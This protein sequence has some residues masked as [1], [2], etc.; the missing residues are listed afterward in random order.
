[1]SNTGHP[2]G[3]EEVRTISGQLEIRFPDG[4]KVVK[5]P[6]GHR[7]TVH[8]DGRQLSELADGTT[9]E[10]Y[11]D[12]SKIQRNATGEVLRVSADGDRRTTYLDGSEVIRR[13]DGVRIVRSPGGAVTETYPDGRHVD[14]DGA[15]N[16]L[17]TF[18]DGRK[19]QTDPAG[20]RAER[21]P[22]GT[23]L[24]TSADPYRYR[25]EV[26][27]DLVEMDEVLARVA[28]GAEAY[29]SGVVR[30]S[31]V[32]T[33]YAAAYRLPDDDVL[34]IPVYRDGV[35]FR[36]RWRPR[37]AGHYIVQ[38]SAETDDEKVAILDD[39]MLVVGDPL[40][41]EAPILVIPPYL[42]TDAATQRFLELTNE[43]RKRRRAQGLPEDARLSQVARQHLVEMLSLGFTG[44]RSPTSG[45]VADRLDRKGIWY[46]TATENLGHAGSVEELHDQLM[47]SAGHRKNILDPT[48]TRIGVAVTRNW[49]EVW[50]VQ[51]FIRD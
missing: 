34:D 9:V 43:T 17:E 48:W 23:L 14:E 42:G 21:L 50:G 26:R 12:G 37:E 29:L 28:P 2:S 39:R 38:V 32:R 11:P 13:G 47:A 22:D 15:G 8:P 5:T 16:R 27:S 49:G 6:E 25:G 1:M 45:T 3:R 46:G 31:E 30:G 7:V 41:L 10:T 40:P 51:V 18:P 35:R 20:N 33:L 4:R 24:K 36:A 44:H 19:V